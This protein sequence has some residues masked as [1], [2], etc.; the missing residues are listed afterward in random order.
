M[1]IWKVGSFEALSGKDVPKV[2]CSARGA[3]GVG[4]PLQGPFWR[5]SKSGRYG[6][7]ATVIR[8]SWNQPKR[9]PTTQNT[10]CKAQKLFTLGEY[11][12]CTHTT[13][14]FF[15]IKYVMCRYTPHI[16]PL[17]HAFPNVHLCHVNSQCVGQ[18]PEDR[19]NGCW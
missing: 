1:G 15:C 5:G 16:L 17:L 9:P 8:A 7:M 2:A 11:L 18:R 3:H 6:G 10:T 13:L 14:F 12:Q 4:I 19:A